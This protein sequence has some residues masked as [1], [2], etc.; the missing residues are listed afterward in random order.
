MLHFQYIEYFIALAAVPVM[1]VFYV[2]L[3][4]WKKKTKKK[5]GDPQLVNELTSGY[6][7][8][9]FRIKFILV[10]IAF[11]LCVF[12]LAGLVTPNGNQKISRKG[13]DMMI[14]LDVSKSMLAQDIK[15][16]RL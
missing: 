11:A 7:P 8:K 5:I 2:Q 13:V 6:S 3:V 10:I 14:A 4:R 15:P 1:I 12:A 9:K 16:S